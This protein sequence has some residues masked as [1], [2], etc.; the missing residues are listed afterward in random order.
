MAK[1]KYETPDPQPMAVPVR[2]QRPESLDQMIR[3][4]IRTQMS[5]QAAQ[6]GHESFEEA[7]DFDTGDDL[8]LR[9]QYEIEGDTPSGSD[10]QDPIPAAGADPTTPPQDPAAPAGGEG[11]AAT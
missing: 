7:E 1:R 5:V 2:F 6:G 9:S 11:S 3:R 4:M 10:P 8:E